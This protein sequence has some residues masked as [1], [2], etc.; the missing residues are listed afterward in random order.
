MF[1]DPRGVPE[2][3]GFDTL[4]PLFVTNGKASNTG[5]SQKTCPM[6]IV[7][8][9]ALHGEWTGGDEADFIHSVFIDTG[10]P[11]RAGPGGCRF[12][13]GFGF[14]FGRPGRGAQ[15]RLGGGGRT[16][17]SAGC[18]SGAGAGGRRA[19]AAFGGVGGRRDT[20]F[21]GGADKGL[22]R[23]GGTQDRQYQEYG[24]A[25]CR[26]VLRRSA[27]RQ[28]AERY[29]RYGAVLDGQH[30]GDRALQRT[31]K[32]YTSKCERLRFGG[33]GLS[34][35]TAAGVRQRAAR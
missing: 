23:G 15:D 1:V 16:A 32:Q 19:R 9:F 20:L 12:G 17:G 14:G 31:E 2:N 30:G 7:T 3:E 22:R 8:N 29:G 27:D 6:R 10:V 34:H 26:S 18:D 5:T 33:G 11:R 21:L 28:R 24:H 25:P 4:L 35:N 13:F